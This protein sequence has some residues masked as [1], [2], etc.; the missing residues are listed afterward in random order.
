METP[1][2]MTK[3]RAKSWRER[4]SRLRMAMIVRPNSASASG[5]TRRIE[6]SASSCCATRL[7]R[8][9]GC[10]SCISQPAPTQVTQKTTASMAA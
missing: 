9:A 1:P 2:P 4:R 10:M 7:S 6:S 8:I 3:S 5:P